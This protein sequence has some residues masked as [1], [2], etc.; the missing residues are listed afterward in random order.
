[1]KAPQS[2]YLIFCDFCG[3]KSVVFKEH[4]MT[5]IPVSAI[6]KRADGK[7][8]S[9]LPRP[10]MLKC[11]LCGR[12]VIMKK[13]KELPNETGNDKFNDGKTGFAGPSI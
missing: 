10:Q 1:M 7:D 8:K 9:T 12:G 13:I 4:K 6:P 2:K 11:P 3:K 5:D